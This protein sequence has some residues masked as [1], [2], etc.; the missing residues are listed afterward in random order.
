[1]KKDAQEIIGEIKNLLDQLAGICEGKLIKKSV[2][3]SKSINIA[4]GASGALSMLI[5]EGFFD[6]PKDISVIMGKLQEIGR[7]YPCPTVAMNL[8]NFT[9]RRVFNRLKNKE[10]KNWQYVLRK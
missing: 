9:K 5:E 1:M 10:T 8:L 6:E 7:Y 2:K 3:Q 4:K